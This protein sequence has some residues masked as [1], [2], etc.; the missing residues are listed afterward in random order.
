MQNLRISAAGSA[1]LSF[2]NQV[3][4]GK[5]AVGGNFGNY[6][7][8]V[9]GTELQIAKRNFVALGNAGNNVF[10]IVFAARH[11]PVVAGFNALNAG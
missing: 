7:Q 9:A 10:N 5:L 6:A 1:C 11:L 2:K 4:K 3:A 8:N